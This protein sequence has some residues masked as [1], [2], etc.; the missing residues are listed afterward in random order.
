MHTVHCSQIFNGVKQIQE[1][2]QEMMAHIRGVLGNPA[3]DLLPLRGRMETLER[4][5]RHLDNHLDRTEESLHAMMILLKKMIK[6]SSAKTVGRGFL[7]ENQG[8]LLMLAGQAILLAVYLLFRRPGNTL[9]RK[10][11]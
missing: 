4:D 1:K 5:I 6:D 11:L 8:V 3:S 9:Q 10:T 2:Q 7:A